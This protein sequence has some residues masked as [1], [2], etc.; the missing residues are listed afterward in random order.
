MVWEM[1]PEHGARIVGAIVKLVLTDN[2]PGIW[3][4]VFPALLN[5]AYVNGN[6]PPFGDVQKRTVLEALQN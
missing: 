1:G 5:L 4:A 3:E 2:Q 6:R